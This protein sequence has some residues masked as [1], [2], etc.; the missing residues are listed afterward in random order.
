MEKISTNINEKKLEK[1][2]KILNNSL[3]GDILSKSNYLIQLPFNSYLL[4]IVKMYIEASKYGT[5]ILDVRLGNFGIKNNHLVA[6]DFKIKG[7]TSDIDIKN[8][9]EIKSDLISSRIS[10]EDKWKSF[11]AK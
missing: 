2:M 5:L 8:L 4:D 3:G 7:L 11:N 10:A 1:A 6:F 9:E